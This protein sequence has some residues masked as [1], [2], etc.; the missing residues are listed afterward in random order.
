MDIGGFLLIFILGVVFWHKGV[1]PFFQ[2]LREGPVPLLGYIITSFFSGVVALFT[3]RR[4]P[5][6]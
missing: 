3:Y 4:K 5:G 2:K 1:R 6:K